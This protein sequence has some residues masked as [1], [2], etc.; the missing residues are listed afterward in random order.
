[1]AYAIPAIVGIVALAAGIAIGL[2]LL[3][4][5]DREKEEKHQR[6]L[7]EAEERAAGA[8]KDAEAK[9]KND[10]LAAREDVDNEAR[11]TRRKLA[12]REKRLEKREDTLDSK[13]SL[14]DKKEQAVERAR[15]KA[16]DL[17]R[18]AEEARAELKELTEKGQRELSRISKLS[19]EQAR[20]EI[21]K[22]VEESIRSETAE[23]IRRGVERAKAEADEEARRIVLDSVHRLAT[24][25][26]AESVVSTIDL[27]GDEMKG[28]IIGREGRNIRA[29]EK[30]TGV[31]VIVDDTPGVVVVSGFDAVRREVARAAM[32][33][34]VSD[35]RIHPARIEDV[36]RK[37]EADVQKDI[38]ETGRRVVRDLGIHGLNGRL[39]KLVGRLKYRTSYG[40]NC[41]QHSIETAQLGGLLAEELKV[42]QR[43]AVRA[44]LL[45]DIGKAVDQD[46][47]GTH[48]DL[49][50]DLVRRADEKPEI[51]NAVEAHHEDVPVTSLYGVIVQVADAI[52]AAR[53]GARRESLEKYIKR[54]E[55]LESIANSHK[56]VDKAYAIQAGRELR[57]IARAAE[58]DEPT[59]ADLARKI[60]KEVEEE[61]NYPG[62]VKVTLI[63]EARFIEYAR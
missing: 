2:A 56:G 36:V 46:T 57:V 27:P 8:E 61:L 39:T 51:V 9:A 45:H 53:P 20:D 10:L 34:L 63:R 49:G 60:A 23:L 4:K 14:I 1:M 42:D 12:E 48:P 52:S 37:T 7:R 22:R 38:D 17:Q 58:V 15:K 11:E 62:E 30:A 21:L 43:L 32:E 55:R 26:V 40:Q 35:G 16:E 54:L 18:E 25:Y 6:Q 44:G 19:R 24:D 3:K 41:L 28:R 5:Q 31:D 47:E 50:A 13:L 29:F 33:K 59:C